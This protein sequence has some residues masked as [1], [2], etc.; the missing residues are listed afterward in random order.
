MGDLNL[1]GIFSILLIYALHWTGLKIHFS[2]LQKIEY[3]F[4]LSHP[5]KKRAI[6]RIW[7]AERAQ[8]YNNF[9]FSPK[10]TLHWYSHYILGEIH[11]TS[12]CHIVI[13]VVSN[14]INYSSVK[15]HYNIGELSKINRMK[16]YTKTTKHLFGVCYWIF[17]TEHQKKRLRAIT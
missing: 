7:V 9:L 1:N 14:R 12:I 13:M 8:V 2:P 10:I 3:K 15:S 6:R 17:L 4:T 5:P 16:S 11:S